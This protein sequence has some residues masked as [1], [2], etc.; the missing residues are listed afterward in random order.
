MPILDDT[1]RAFS[2]DNIK[3]SPAKHGVYVL[4]RSGKLIYY[5]RAIGKDVT[6]RSRLGDH[7]RGDEG[8]CTQNATAYKRE[9][10][11]AAISRE[12]ELLEDFERVN[13]GL[14]ECNQR[15]G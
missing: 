2:W 7:K 11:E 6:I 14:P 5:G 13:G 1:I 10:T 8:H 3:V 4:F 9:V 15:V 12:R